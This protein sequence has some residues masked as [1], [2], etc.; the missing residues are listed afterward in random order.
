VPSVKGKKIQILGDSLSY[1][2]SSPGWFM[3]SHLGGAGAEVRINAR[4]GRS[5]WNFYDRED[6]TAQLAA[7]RAWDP[8][9]VIV[10][11]GTNDVG[12]SMSKDGARMAQL[13]RELAAGGAEVWAFGPPSFPTGTKHHE[14]SPAVVAMMRQVFGGKFIDLRPITSDLLSSAHRTSDQIHFTTDGA[15]LA[16]ERMADRFERAGG[17]A[18][19]VAIG[20]VATV[21]LWLWLR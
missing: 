2:Q 17:G 20:V 3:G 5:A 8:D 1:G 16:G 12:L 10:E 19:G 4:V 14:G 18:A 13:K 7:I 9:I 6:T 15:K 11:L 21:A